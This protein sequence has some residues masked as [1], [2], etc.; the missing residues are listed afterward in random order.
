MIVFDNILLSDSIFTSSPEILARKSSLE[1]YPNP[2]T[3]QIQVE[4]EGKD[5][6]LPFKIYDTQGKVMQAGVADFSGGKSR[7]EFSFDASGVFILVIDQ[8][9]NRLQRLFLKK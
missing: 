5:A 8:A 6:R 2:A 9:D 1:I 3:H 7:I 4:L